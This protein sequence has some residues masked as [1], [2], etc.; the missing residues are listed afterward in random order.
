MTPTSVIIAKWIAEGTTL[1]VLDVSHNDI[2]FSDQ[3]AGSAFFH[4]FSKNTSLQ[5][6]ILSNNCWAADF[7]NRRP[8]SWKV[9]NNELLLLYIRVIRFTYDLLVV[10]TRC[11]SRILVR[12]FV[13]GVAGTT[14]EG[15]A[16]VK[17][18][19]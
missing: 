15:G 7:Q 2:D 19:M 10:L 13:L 5:K 18:V 16:R 9:T 6:L 3:V 8:T 14:S 17:K 4:A 11:F 12:L 1:R